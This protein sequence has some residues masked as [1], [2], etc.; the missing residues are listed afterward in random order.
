[1]TFLEDLQ[2]KT[3]VVVWNE[4]LR[5]DG[6]VINSIRFASIPDTIEYQRSLHDYDNDED[7][8][9]DFMV[10]RWAWIEEEPIRGK[11]REY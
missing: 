7:A 10:V 11:A 3:E 8:L 2:T 5:T 1:M 4:P 9:M 6:P